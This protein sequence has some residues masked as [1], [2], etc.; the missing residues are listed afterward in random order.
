MIR[1]TF[2]IVVMDAFH[3][4]TIDTD[5]AAGIHGVGRPISALL[6]K[7]FAAGI[8]LPARFASAHHDIAF[9]AASVT[10]IS[11]IRYTAF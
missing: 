5:C 3:R 2:I 8:V 7:T 10:V 1:V 11:A 6:P 9:A 4:I